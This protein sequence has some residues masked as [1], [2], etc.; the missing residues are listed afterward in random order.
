MLGAGTTLPMCLQLTFSQRWAAA[1]GKQS[2]DHEPDGPWGGGT[3]SSGKIPWSLWA[4]PPPNRG[5]PGPT[6][7]WS[8]GP[9][10]RLRFVCTPRS[11]AR[12]KRAVSPGARGSL[13]TQSHPPPRTPQV[14]GG[15]WPGA[16]TPPLPFWKLP[17][18]T[19]P[20]VAPGQAHVQGSPPFL[21]GKSRFQGCFPLLSHHPAHTQPRDASCPGSASSVLTFSSTSWRSWSHSRVSGFSR[22]SVQRRARR[23][24]SP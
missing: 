23:R 17:L 16:H 13:S 24:D 22:F 18:G 7:T 19:D 20:R 5:H 3:T 8:A 6:G 9:G 1:C 12:Q 11:A 15:L 14:G 2:G 4:A 21:P 10:A